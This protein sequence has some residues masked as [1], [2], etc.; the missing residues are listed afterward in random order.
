MCIC[1][2]YARVV[3]MEGTTVVSRTLPSI[4]LAYLCDPQA[5]AEYFLH[6]LSE[7]FKHDLLTAAVGL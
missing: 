5:Q 2:H 4:Y 7:K 3:C 6:L 1:R